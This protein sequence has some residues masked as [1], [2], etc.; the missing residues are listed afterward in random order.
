VFVA[1]RSQHAMRMRHFVACGLSG[2]TNFSTL[3]HK[4]HDFR[5]KKEVIGHK[6]FLYKFLVKHLAF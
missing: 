3:L 2:C 1:L 5:K 6:M 4:R